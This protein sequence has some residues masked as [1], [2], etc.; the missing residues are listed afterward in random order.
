MPLSFKGTH[1]ETDAPKVQPRH[2]WN[3]EGIHSRYNRVHE[4]KIYPNITEA[5]VG[6]VKFFNPALAANATTPSSKVIATA[7]EK[8]NRSGRRSD[9]GMC[10]RPETRN[11]VYS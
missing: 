4:P 9:E 3:N 7:W 8:K 10:M 5:P 1:N 6:A 11:A 2:L